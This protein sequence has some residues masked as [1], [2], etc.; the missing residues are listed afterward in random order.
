MLSAAIAVSQSTIV[1]LE[2]YFDADWRIIPNGI[3]T[4]LFTPDATRPPAIRGDVPAVLFLGRFD[5]RNGLP[6]LIEAFKRVKGRGRRAQLV[7]VGDGSLRQR[8][9]RQ[10]GRDPDITFTG[11]V[12]DGRPQYYAN[13]AI[14]ACPTTK[15]SF[16]ITLLE[17]MSC[18]T[19]IVCSDILGFRDVVMH[20]REA[21]MVPSGDR[22]ALANALV[23]LIDDE[24][25]RE[26]LGATGRARSLE[27]DWR[28]VTSA[29]LDVYRDVLAPMRLPLAV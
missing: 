10:A 25:L 22:D 8:Y 4:A 21:L 29:V 27:Y 2:R 14:Y 1:A 6:T 13:S 12:L 23:R 18:C 28:H 9:H 15:A 5:P 16:G 3:D 17:A 11:A 7:V 20:G 26:R 19:P 24:R